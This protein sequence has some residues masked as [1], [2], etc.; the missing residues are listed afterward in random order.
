MFTKILKN[1]DRVLLLGSHHNRFKPRK[2]SDTITSKRSTSEF[3]TKS[4]K[5]SLQRAFNRAKQQIFFNPDMKIFITLTYKGATHTPDD[6]LHDVKMLIKRERRSSNKDIKYIY[7]L[8]Y[9]KRGSIHVHMIAND[10]FT[11]R[12]NR[13]GY[14]EL[15]YWKHGF[16]SY[17]TIKDFDSNFK[18]YLYLFKYMRKSQRIGNSFVHSSRNL[19]NF[20]EIPPDEFDLTLYTTLSQERNHTQLDTGVKL[21]FYHYYLIRDTIEPH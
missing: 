6:V 17:L 20:I 14:K 10:T 13:N 19:N 16:S 2:K 1:D 21:F 5:D 11:T 7:V 9:Q 12:I 3:N 4:Y 18:P 15:V 8:E